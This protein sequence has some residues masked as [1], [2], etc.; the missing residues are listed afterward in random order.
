MRLPWL[1]I[2]LILKTTQAAVD[3]LLGPLP[4]YC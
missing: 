1:A 2:G 4:Q 3:V